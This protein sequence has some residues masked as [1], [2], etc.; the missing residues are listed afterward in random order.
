MIPAN[1]FIKTPKQ[2]EATDLHA[3]FMHVMLYGGSRSG[4]TAIDIRNIVQ[5][6]LPVQS[7]HLIARFRFNHVKQS[8]VFDT[9][10]KVMKL[11]F[12]HIKY[13][14]NKSDWFVELDNGSEIWFAGLD[15]NERVDKIL[16]KEYSTIKLNECTQISWAARNTV[17]SRLAENSGLPL[18]AMYDCNPTSKKHW[19][20][21]VFK[22]GETPEGQ[23]I[24]N[25]EDYAC[26]QM[27]PLDNLSNLPPEYI[28]LL[29]SLPERDRIRFLQGEF[30]DDIEGALWNF[31]IIAKARAKESKELKKKILS[32][33]PA[34]TNRE[35]SDLTGLVICGLDVNN[36]GAVLGDYSIKASPNE[37]ATR[38]VNIFHKEECSEI[39][40][41]VNQG[42]DL[43]KTIIHNIDSN[44]PI[45]EV[46]A[47]TGKFA[48]AEPIAALYEQEKVWH[49]GNL[50]ELE[51]ELMEYVPLNSKKSPDRLDAMVWGL[52]YL[53]LKKQ[54]EYRMRSL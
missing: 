51:A 22:L 9:F 32:I 42:G 37:W 7:R 24:K 23:K 46:R 12:P 1:N 27:N 20:Y 52:T 43:V 8:V 48:R 49:Q 35:N 38:A 53:M 16:G 28:T 34:V 5:R 15:D 31:E 19:T 50:N 36:H 10:P 18:L 11:A 45:K 30:Q 25:I 44:I 13:K 47:S 6:A 40:V 39:V 2:I 14:L 54:G 17:M 33:D 4:K 21:T 3:Q 41:E 26:L 29:E